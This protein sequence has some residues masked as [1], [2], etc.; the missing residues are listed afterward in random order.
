MQV[1]LGKYNLKCD[2]YSLGVV[3][4]QMLSLDLESNLIKTCF[5]K[6]P[7]TSLMEANNASMFLKNFTEQMIM[8]NYTKETTTL[9]RLKGK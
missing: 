4:Y 6:F 2:L 1:I 8:R 3:L 7:L 9:K 5:S